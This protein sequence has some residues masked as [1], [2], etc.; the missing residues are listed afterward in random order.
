MKK[1]QQYYTYGSNKDS[2]MHAIC[3]AFNSFGIKNPHYICND[4]ASIFFSYNGEVNCARKDDKILQWMILNN[5]LYKKLDIKI[6]PKFKIGDSIEKIGERNV[7]TVSNIDKKIQVYYITDGSNNYD[8]PFAEQDDYDL[9][10][11]TFKLYDYITDGTV[12]GSVEEVNRLNKMYKIDCCTKYGKSYPSFYI[13]FSEQEK[14]RKVIFKN[15]KVGEYL[16][17]DILKYNNEYVIY[18]AKHDKKGYAIVHTINNEELIVNI[19]LLEPI[20][21]TDNILLQNG[22]QF[23][24]DTFINKYKNRSLILHKDKINNCYYITESSI[25]IEYFHELQ[26]LYNITKWDK[27]LVL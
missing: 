3:D 17:N 9:S 16:T 7:Y 15:T 10:G 6:N 5:P 14:W 24:F 25:I 11:K 22:F 27:R 19:D 13:S 23:N 1:D 4:P 26:R 2:V 18:H 20:P 21:L 12:Y 8:L